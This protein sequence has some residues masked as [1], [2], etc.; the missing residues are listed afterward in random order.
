MTRAFIKAVREQFEKELTT[1]VK[2]EKR[3]EILE[4][5]DHAVVEVAYRFVA[6]QSAMDDQYREAPVNRS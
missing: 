3:R 2:W 4:R 6:D 1:T 5:F